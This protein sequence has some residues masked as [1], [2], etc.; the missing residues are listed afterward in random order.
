MP[1][2]NTGGPLLP[3]APGFD[4][5]LD[6]ALNTLNLEIGAGSPITGMLGTAVGAGIGC[7]VGLPAGSVVSVVT[8]TEFVMPEEDAVGCLGGAAIG[9]AIGG[10]AAQAPVLL[11]AS[12]QFLKAMLAPDASRRP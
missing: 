10:V 12:G 7:L 2:H 3:G 9:A 8:S 5:K 6:R 1:R 4:E 11:G